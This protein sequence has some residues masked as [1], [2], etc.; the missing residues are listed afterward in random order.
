MQISDNPVRYK[1][2]FSWLLKIVVSAICLWFVLNKLKSSEYPPGELLLDS[3]LLPVFCLVLLLMPLNW[4]LEIQKWRFSIANEE[5]SFKEGMHAVFAGL[6]LNWVLPFTLG[7]VGARL[8]NV[9]NYKQSGIA[10]M[11][12]RV[13]SIGITSLISSPP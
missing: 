4:Y 3:S 7:D 8:S 5:L 12:T 1:E 2:K 13:I 10:L 6:A 11:L 9:K